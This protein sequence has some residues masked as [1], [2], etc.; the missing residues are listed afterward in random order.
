L[1]NRNPDDAKC[2]YGHFADEDRQGFMKKFGGATLDS[3]AD[4]GELIQLQKSDISGLNLKQKID[5]RDQN[6]IPP[7]RYQGECGACYAFASA[8]VI[9]A[10]NA[11]DRRLKSP[12][13][14]NNDPVEPLSPQYLIDCSPSGA[15]N[16]CN[17][18]RPINVLQNVASDSSSGGIPLE[19]CHKYQKAAS[20]KCPTNVTCCHRRKI[21]KAKMVDISGPIEKELMAALLNA[22]PVLVIVNINEM[23]QF[24]NG[25]GIIK[26]H[27]CDPNTRNHAVSIV[28]YDYT[29]STPYYIVKNSWSEI[30]GTKGYA[31][32]QAG[33]NACGVAKNVVSTCVR[34]CQ[35]F[36][37]DTKSIFSTNNL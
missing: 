21:Q 2:G 33:S 4:L 16:G 35:A 15:A 29:G 3:K 17:G 11:I 36:A 32:L 23:W 6:V 19:A 13:A 27:Q 28:G 20:G 30:W 8:D 26:A 18:G 10:Q 14:K 7:I 25:T 12:S 22:G 34:N 31:K 37:K 9:A 24:Y 5:W 1:T